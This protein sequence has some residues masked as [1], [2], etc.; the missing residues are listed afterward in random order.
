MFKKLTLLA[1]GLV[2]GAALASGSISTSALAQS[3]KFA[4]SW[5][6]TP[7][8][9]SADSTCTNGTCTGNETNSDIEVEMATIHVATHKSVLIGVSAQ[10][11]I[12]LITQAKGKS[13]GGDSSAL[14]E[15][16]V[17]VD[18]ALVD[19]ESG[20]VCDIA[21]SSS[22]TLKSE[23]RKL[24]VKATATEVDPVGV[25]ELGGVPVRCP[26]KRHD[27]FPRGDR[28]I[29][30]LDL[31]VRI[32]SDHLHGSVVTEQLIGDILVEPGVFSECIDLFPML[33]QPP[34]P[35]PDEV[36]RGLEPCPEQKRCQGREL[37]V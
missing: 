26:E 27:R 32:A 14:A 13:G 34:E 9:T 7:I 2:A 21:P 36:R 25:P 35:V 33:E 16:S 8:V 1:T 6:T 17:D 30:D 24:A 15:G 11:G 31:G 4:A 29:A 37:V 23:M 20:A 5:D 3:A 12:H 22:V 19:P 28:R 18:L 10:I